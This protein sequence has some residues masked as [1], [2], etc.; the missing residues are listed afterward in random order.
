MPVDR[1]TDAGDKRV[2]RLGANEASLGEATS[3]DRSLT[4]AA[5]SSEARRPNGIECAALSR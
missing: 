5:V 4:L 3:L 1:P 2:R